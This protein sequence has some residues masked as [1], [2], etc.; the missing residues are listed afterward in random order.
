MALWTTSSAAHTDCFFCAEAIPILLLREYH[1]R[2]AVFRREWVAHRHPVGG[3][4]PR[5][6][7][8]AA[9]IALLRCSFACSRDGIADLRTR[10]FSDGGLVGWPCG[11]VPA[12]RL[13][14]A[15]NSCSLRSPAGLTLQPTRFVRTCSSE[16]KSSRPPG[17]PVPRFDSLRFTTVQARPGSRFAAHLPG[18][19]RR[20][21]ER[22]PVLKFKVFPQQRAWTNSITPTKPRPSEPS[23]SCRLGR[24]TFLVMHAP[25]CGQ[26]TQ[27]PFRAPVV[28][29]PPLLATALSARSAFPES[30][31]SGMRREAGPPEARPGP[32]LVG[33]SSRG[34]YA[35]W[36]GA[37]APVAACGS[38]FGCS[39]TG[40][41]HGGARGAFVRGAPIPAP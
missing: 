22:R 13:Y 41:Q 10:P 12:L 38:R 24:L 18:G 32:H 36:A 26:A 30:S 8:A 33:A 19:P 27:M 7:S 21:P 35:H 37:A 6:D 2:F 16:S 3:V 20:N 23:G 9:R 1:R 14:G 4:P 25:T 17:R 34:P 15:R 29:R 11:N 31:R 40:W 39:P 28:R 5:A